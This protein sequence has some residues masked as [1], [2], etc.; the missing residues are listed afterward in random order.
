[1]GYQ[2]LH[3]SRYDNQSRSYCELQLRTEEM[4]VHAEMGMADH[5][6]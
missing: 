4:D 1:M 5:S 6:V 3:I 2:L